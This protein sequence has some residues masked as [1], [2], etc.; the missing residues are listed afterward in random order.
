MKELFLNHLVL[1]R[2]GLKKLGK[3]QCW[4]GAC[5]NEPTRPAALGPRAL[6]V[7]MDLTQRDIVQC[8]G[9][10]GR[11]PHSRAVETGVLLLGRVEV[12]ATGEVFSRVSLKAHLTCV[13]VPKARTR[14]GPQS[15]GAGMENSGKELYFLKPPVLCSVVWS[16]LPCTFLV[17]RWSSPGEAGATSQPAPRH[18]FW[19][20]QSPN[21]QAGK[22]AQQKATS[23]SLPVGQG[24]V[25][26]VT[27]R[28]PVTS[29]EGRNS[30]P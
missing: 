4:E 2:P 25:T 22:T 18:A 15:Q 7:K 11:N 10:A 28:E 8:Y 23:G 24:L 16:P 21:V 26:K 12:R 27:G 9:K 3:A 5:K 17:P 19:T 6:P 1:Q 20:R 14:K 30:S 13:V 29:T